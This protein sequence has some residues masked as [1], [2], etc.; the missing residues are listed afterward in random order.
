MNLLLWPTRVNKATYPIRIVTQGGGQASHQTLSQRLAALWGEGEAHPGEPDLS[1]CP[2]GCQAQPRDLS[3][4]APG[5]SSGQG[6][7]EASELVMRDGG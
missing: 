1:E 5:K 4:F 3:R 7:L 2:S 6:G